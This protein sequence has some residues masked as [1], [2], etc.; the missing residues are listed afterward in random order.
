MYLICL[1]GAD[2]FGNIIN[3]LPVIGP[4]RKLITSE[5]K[6]SIDL[7]LGPQVKAFIGSY[8]R[9]AVKNMISFILNKENTA[10]LNTVDLAYITMIILLLQ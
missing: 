3:S 2:I 10:A 1:Q 6:R 5:F 8:N 4:I 9:V 7:V